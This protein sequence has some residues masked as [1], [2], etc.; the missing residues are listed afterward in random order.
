MKVNPE[1]CAFRVGSSKP[2]GFLVSNKGIE[3]NPMNIRVIGDIHKVLKNQKEV[4][5]LTRR[6]VALDR[7]ISCS[8]KRCHKIFVALK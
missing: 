2:L 8:C 6:I 1:K 4:M 7:F 3:A 5:R